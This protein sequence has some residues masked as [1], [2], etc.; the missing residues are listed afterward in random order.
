[1]P[2]PPGICA[3]PPAPGDAGAACN[4]TGCN[5]GGSATLLVVGAVGTMGVGKRGTRVVLVASGMAA[6]ADGDGAD[7][8]FGVGLAL[9]IEELLFVALVAGRSHCT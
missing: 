8:G 5:G 2:L 7:V 4:G 6:A 1:M 3:W 9:A